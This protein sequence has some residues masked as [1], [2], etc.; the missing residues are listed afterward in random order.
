MSSNL[1]LVPRSRRVRG[2]RKLEI[3][4]PQQQI[5][6]KCKG[7][8]GLINKEGIMS[9]E[10]GT[11]IHTY[12][13]CSVL[14]IGPPSRISLPWIFSVKS[15]RGVLIPCISPPLVETPAQ[16]GLPGGMVVQEQSQCPQK[17]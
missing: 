14:Q 13:Y 7:G 4:I 2:G 5:N 11:Y 10:Y 15:C 6:A 17:R 16:S 1:P 3:N 8:G 9:S 12:L